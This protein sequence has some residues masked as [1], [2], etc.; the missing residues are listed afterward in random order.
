M[1]PDA[2]AI[3]CT[4]CAAGGLAGDDVVRCASCGAAYPTVSGMPVLFGDLRRYLAP[5]HSV[6]LQ[7]MRRCGAASRGMVAAAMPSD[8]GCDSRG[9]AERRWAAVY[10]SSDNTSMYRHI[11]D[12]MPPAADLTILEHGCSVGVFSRLLKGEGAVVTGV[13][14]SFPALSMAVR[15]APDIPYV[16]ADS[17]SLRCG[18]FDFVISLNML[19]VIE[20]R[21]LLQ[22]MASRAVRYVV[23]ADP[24]DYAR[25]DRTVS[26]PLDG[27]G[28]RRFLRG[29]GFDMISGTASPSFI[30]WSLRISP[31]TTIQY[32]VDL[33]I[34]ERR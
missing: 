3:G 23:V 10:Q 18:R 21:I 32:M 27:T 1:N 24:Y 29:M 4:A 7:M 19:E 13:D 33:V 17:A 2:G 22:S 20:P 11:L 28:V 8:A 12:M 30:P 15:Q 16:L 5:R 6:G 9:A 25:G 14:A 34:G 31:R 26:E